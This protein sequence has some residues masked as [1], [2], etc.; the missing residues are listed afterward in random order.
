MDLPG[1]MN[2]AA[3]TAKGRYLVFMSPD[4]APQTTWFTSLKEGIK[5]HA[6]SRIF[7]AHIINRYNNIVHSGVVLNANHQPVSAYLHLDGGFPHACKT[8]SFQMVDHF[9]CTEKKFFLSI[10]GFETRSGRYLFLDLC[11]R[12]L[13][14]SHDPETVI[15]LPDVE[16]LLLDSPRHGLT[17]D[18]AI[19]FY[20][21]WHGVLWESEDALLSRDGVST[22]QLDAARMTRAMEITPLK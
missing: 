18:D 9:I 13:K 17:H 14:I 16:L 5:T 19:F 1:V 10:G 7:G 8:R 3:V 11:L 4:L 22:L 12:T 15:Y 20:S 2:Q 6:A 21:R